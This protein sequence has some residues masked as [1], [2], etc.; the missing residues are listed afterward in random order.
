[1]S[2]SA[3]VVIAASL[4]TLFAIPVLAH[5]Q[6]RTSRVPF[7]RIADTL[8]P[9][10]LEEFATPGAAVAVIRGR[11]IAWMRGFGVADLASQQSVTPRTVF[12]VGSISKSVTSWGVLRLVQTGQL[13]LD[14]PISSYAMEW[15]LPPTSFDSNG[16]TVRR[17]LSHTAGVS[18][19]S[20]T[21]FAPSE[22]LPSLE[23]VLSGI[24][25]R[26][27]GVRLSMQ[28]GTRF[29]YSGGGYALLQLLVQERSHQ[30]FADYMRASV[31][32]PL[33]M[34]RSAFE[35]TSTVTATAATPYDRFGHPASA[36]RF[37]EV[38]AAGL[39]TTA[40]DLA[41]LAQAELTATPRARDRRVL[42]PALVRLM[43][44]VAPPATTWGL[45]HEVLR[46]SATGMVFA[47]HNGANT[48]WNAVIRVVPSTGDG[49]VVLTNGA[50]G[51][52]VVQRV[53]CAWERSLD[54]R[55]S[56]RYCGAPGVR[57]ALYRFYATG[58]VTAAL[59][60][61]AELRRNSPHS[62]L[63][64]A[65][66]LVG[67]AYDL[68]H[69]GALSD[70]VRVFEANAREF[71]DDWNGHDSLGEAYLASGDTAR[72]VSE[73]QR[74]VELN[75]DNTNGRELLRRIERARTPQ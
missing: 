53:A 9:R 38:A 34:T 2:A 47:G 70:A 42:S 21:P 6:V 4:V 51:F 49:L 32:E 65:S 52:G 1:M 10:A 22:R 50:N 57:M 61:Y 15:T 68:L 3:P 27:D 16:V 23:Q 20:A 45:G 36:E 56:T 26:S 19:P 46:D 59:A 7:E 40:E 75:A 31:L 55:S 12:N 54:P 25:N 13:E 73:Y 66:Q 43:Q 35:W 29:E 14:R 17:L 69:A 8:V 39:Q 71:P 33:G 60:R 28:P 37:T 30:R 72:A 11:T 74:S 48:G 58:G 64:D 63:F 24:P 5:A 41:L 67:F 44:S 62:Y 18:K